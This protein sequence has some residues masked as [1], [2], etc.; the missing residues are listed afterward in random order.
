[1]DSNKLNNWLTLG[2]NV[3]V[4]IG[5][6]LLVYELRQAQHLAET[7]SA[8]RRLEQIQAAQTQM[9]LSDTLPAIRVK[10]QTS[11]AKSLT[12]VELFRLQYWERAVINRMSSQYILYERGYLDDRTAQQFV[13]TA[14]NWLPYWE[15]LGLDIEVADSSFAS[16]VREAAGRK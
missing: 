6:A 16:A 3:G 13:Q 11:G 9:A 15:D 2:A 10:A 14:A 4:L 8:V 1:M 12:P 7:E 5:L